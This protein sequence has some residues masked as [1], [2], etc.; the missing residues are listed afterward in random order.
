MKNVVTSNIGRNIHTGRSQGKRDVSIDADALAAQ[1]REEIR[2]E[3]RY[4]T[5]MPN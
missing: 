5:N 4:G 3:V 1:L 2:G